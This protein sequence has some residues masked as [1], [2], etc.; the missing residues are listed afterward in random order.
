MQSTFAPLTVHISIH[1]ISTCPSSIKYVYYYM[2]FYL[3]NN[4]AYNFHIPVVPSSTDIGNKLFVVEQL[5]Y[6]TLYYLR[7]IHTKLINTIENSY[8]YI[9][10]NL[11]HHTLLHI[12]KYSTS[13]PAIINIEC[14]NAV[15]V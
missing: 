8:I 13:L 15:Y 5:A 2:N 3:H 9:Y 14:E 1:I 4:E 12:Y 11:V 10:S 7:S 6:R